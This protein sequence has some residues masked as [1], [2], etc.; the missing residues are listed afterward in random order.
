M[1]SV[2]LIGPM[3]T[4][5]TTVG[6]E[7]AGIL[8][9]EFID[10]DSVF[11][12][13]HGSIDYFVERNGWERFREW[14]SRIILDITRRYADK[15]AVFSPGGGAVASEYESYRE[16]NAEA[17]RGFGKVV[18]LL[19][20]NN[21]KINAAI[22]AERVHNHPQSRPPLKYTDGKVMDMLSVLEHR[23]PLYL[24]AADEV[25]YTE[26]DPV[27]RVAENISELI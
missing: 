5:K 8:G 15:P 14:E 22:L 6:K 13:R 4:G 21:M 17:L 23:H 26:G 10:G 3:C 19:P 20:D 16:T 18:Y 24:A 27:M 7:V 1:G 25:V 9:I 2:V 12:A 11:E